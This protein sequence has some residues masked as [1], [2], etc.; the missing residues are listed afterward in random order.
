MGISL[1][2]VI[3]RGITSEILALEDQLRALPSDELRSRAM[4]FGI[5][6]VGAVESWE[7]S[8]SY[9]TATWLTEKGQAKATRLIAEARFAYWERWIKIVNPVASV[10][11]ALLA[12]A[13]AALALWFRLHGN[14]G[15]G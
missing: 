9:G 3:R 10:I 7:H 14:P 12:F 11:I 13:V 1:H 6:L 4:R 2:Y 8:G 15:C 5:D